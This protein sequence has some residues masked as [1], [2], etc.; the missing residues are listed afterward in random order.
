MEK[1][2]QERLAWYDKVHYDVNGRILIYDFDIRRVF[3]EVELNIGLEPT[4]NN[5]LMLPFEL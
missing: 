1:D 2:A 3:H 5:T 4:E